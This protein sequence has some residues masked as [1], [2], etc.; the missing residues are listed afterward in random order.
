M[1]YW[2]IKC[3]QKY[4]L[5]LCLIECNSI[6]F[7]F[8]LYFFIFFVAFNFFTVPFYPP[9]FSLLPPPSPSVQILLLLFFVY[10]ILSSTVVHT[11]L[12]PFYLPSIT[13]PYSPSFYFTPLYFLLSLSPALEMLNEGTPPE[14][15][16]FKLFYGN[17]QADILFGLIE[18]KVSTVS[19]F[20]RCMLSVVRFISFTIVD[21]HFLSNFCLL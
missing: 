8:V 1:L 17:R 21:L 16:T 2:I 4:F 20:V 19:P 10:L 14:E 7:N 15:I 6:F 18:E 3:C 9:S 11:I 5:L 12:S 13:P